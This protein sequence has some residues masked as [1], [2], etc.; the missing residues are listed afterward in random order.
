VWTAPGLAKAATAAVQF[1]AAATAAAIA[2]AFLVGASG[3][4]GVVSCWRG[5]DC[6]VRGWQ[7][8]RSSFGAAERVAAAARQYPAKSI[9]CS[10]TMAVRC[11][12]FFCS[13]RVQTLFR[14]C[15]ETISCT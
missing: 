11:N 6:T 7:L 15:A 1:A 4:G 5:T 9:A 12:R 2:A 10:F 14:S 3:T 8:D 13:G